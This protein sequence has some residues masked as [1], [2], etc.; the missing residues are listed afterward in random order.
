VVV[1]VVGGVCLWRFGS[2]STALPSSEHHVGDGATTS[3]PT[4]VIR[5]S[6]GAEERRRIAEQITR[7]VAARKSAAE[8]AHTSSTAPPQLPA[9]PTAMDSP[10]H[11]LEQMQGA[12]AQVKG[13]V[14]DCVKQSATHI[15]GFKAN[16]ALTG[17]P[18]IGTLIDASRLT[19]A[20]GSPVPAAFD[21]CV[22][23]VMQTLELPP[24]ALGDSFAVNYE[25]QFD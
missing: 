6:H 18:D 22:R 21:A 13:F 12:L 14:A 9:D 24:M 16:L 25:F 8:A 4:Q 7:A 23:D 5:L 15:S 17:D 20:D 10:Q 11:V 19:T 3:K 1:A 2:K